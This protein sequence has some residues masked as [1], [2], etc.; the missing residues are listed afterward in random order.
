ML[1][2]VNL[3]VGPTNDA[4]V[5]MLHPSVKKKIRIKRVPRSAVVSI[6]R[7]HDGPSYAQL[8]RKAREEVTLDNL[9]ISG[10]RIRWSANGAALIEINGQDR[11]EKAALLASKI[12]EVLSG[13]ATV[14]RPVASGELYVRGFDESIY[15]EDVVGAIATCG[16][17]NPGDITAGA[18]NR[19]ANVCS[20]WIRCPLTTAIKVAEI[21]SLKV[22]WSLARV[23]LQQARPVQCFRCWK[24]GHVSGKCKSVIDWSDACFRCGKKGHSARDCSAA[25]IC[26]VCSL[27]GFSDKHRMG[28]NACKSAASARTEQVNRSGNNKL[29]PVMRAPSTPLSGGNAL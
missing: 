2:L 5:D 11:S 12:G 4:P 14:T 1:V 27:A 24:Y 17:C 18:I 10:T 6:K 22:G 26:G 20:I 28:S 21:G 23:A 25:P 7:N 3:R 9:G 16:G 19:M 29:N 15:V 8:L 13:E